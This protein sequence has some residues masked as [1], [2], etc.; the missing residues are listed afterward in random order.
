MSSVKSI[1]I[2][3]FTDE[4]GSLSAAELKDYIDWKPE[5][6]YYVTDVKQK[7]GGHA[8]IGEKKIYICV[9]GE[10]TAR[11]HDGERWEEYK[12]KGPDDALIMDEMNY[13]EFDDFSQGA[14]LLSISNMNYDKSKY[15]Y[16]FD[17][18]ISYKN[19]QK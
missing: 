12:L 1:K 16:D 15:I 9:Q 19:S 14:V 8:V 10:I 7:R 5:R 13:R 11:I 2:P 6:I 3:T 4:R 17:E 18:F